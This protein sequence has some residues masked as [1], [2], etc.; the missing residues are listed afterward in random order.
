[1][2]GSCEKIKIKAYFEFCYTVKGP[3]FAL[4]C[5]YR[6]TYSSGFTMLLHAKAPS[7]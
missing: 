4:H 7:L 5:S 1:M 3:L 2:D 6:P